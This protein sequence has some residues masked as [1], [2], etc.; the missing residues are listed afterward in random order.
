MMIAAV[1]QSDINGQMSK[2]AGRAE[3]GESAADDHD[4]RAL[5]RGLGR[6]GRLMFCKIGHAITLGNGEAGE[7]SPIK[8]MRE[9][10]K[11]WQAHAKSGISEGATLVAS[12]YDRRRFVGLVAGVSRGGGGSAGGGQPA[13]GQAA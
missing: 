4:A 9:T 2:T 12:S 11:K 8:V 13:A 5:A 6:C 3:A 1:D 10:G 7:K